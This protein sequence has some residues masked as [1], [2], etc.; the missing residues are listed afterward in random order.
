MMI[1]RDDCDDDDDDDLLYIFETSLQYNIA[2][3]IKRGKSWYSLDG[4]ILKRKE[5]K[6]KLSVCKL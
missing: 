4:W 3:Q 1:D 5:E 2:F 6:T